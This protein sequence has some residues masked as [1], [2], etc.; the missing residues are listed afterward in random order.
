MTEQHQE[1]KYPTLK[2]N[3]FK[4]EKL[5]VGF[6]EIKKTEYQHR[7]SIEYN[8]AK[9]DE[10]PNWKPLRMQ[11]PQ[12]RAYRGVYKTK[13]KSLVCSLTSDGVFVDKTRN[14]A[15]LCEEKKIH[16]ENAD[17]IALFKA[18]D[19]VDNAVID[20]ITNNKTKF[21][22][23]KKQKLERM[24]VQTKYVDNIKIPNDTEK[25]TPFITCGIQEYKGQIKTRIWD[26]KKNEVAIK[27]I[28]GPIDMMVTANIK[29][30]SFWFGQNGCGAKAVL[31]S[32]IILK[33]GTPAMD[34]KPE[35]KF[36]YLGDFMS[37]DELESFKNKDANPLKESQIKTDIIGEDDDD[38]ANDNK[39]E[40]T[41]SFAVSEPATKKVKV[42]AA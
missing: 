31:N 40:Q 26:L 19:A 1:N 42:S 39:D 18:L 21:G 30:D 11:T 12:L 16:G 25:Y 34:Y 8:Y 36:D 20:Y 17:V 28:P 41:S 9:D 23:N 33:D 27:D 29:L 32:M 38:V 4:I 37:T 35:P 14:D 22:I 15:N 10:E 2:W 13:F 5:R 24:V 7:G 6:G 3:A